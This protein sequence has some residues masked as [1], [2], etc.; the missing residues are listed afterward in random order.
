MSYK[1]IGRRIDAEKAYQEEL[2]RLMSIGIPELKKAYDASHRR[3]QYLMGK[4]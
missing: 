1:E 2:L 4:L 3:V